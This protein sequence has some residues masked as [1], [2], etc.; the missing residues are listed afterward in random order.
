MGIKLAIMFGRVMHKRLFPKVNA[1]NYGIYYLALPL[2]KLQNMGLPLNR[3]AAISFYEVDHGARDGSD[4]E[5]WAR[6]ILDTYNIT[7]AN[8]E[9]TLMCMPRIFGYVFNPVSFWLCHDHNGQI[10]AVLC[11]V[12]NTFG[13]THTYLCAHADRSP[14]QDNDILQGEKLF[15]VSPFLP[16][17]GHYEFRFDMSGDQCNIA[18]HYFAADGRKQ[19]ATAL[20]GALRPMNE[21]NIRKAFWMYP[22]VT[23]KAITLI[24][25]Q[26]LKVVLKGIKYIP[27]PLQRNKKTSAT[28]NI[29]NL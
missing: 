7:E 18:V 29:T 26:A 21:T 6:S 22:L 19:L 9:I 28:R 2:S 10:R 16:R 4:L 11:E 15:H 14:I 23:L 8:G 25:W 13:E 27:K 3:P 12:N 20:Y 17:D 1:F 24:H 5:N